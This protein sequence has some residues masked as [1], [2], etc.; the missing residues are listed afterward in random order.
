MSKPEQRFKEGS[1]EQF[2]KNGKLRCHGLAKSKIRQWREKYNDYD[3][4]S[5]DLWPEC[6]CENSA[7]EGQYV[8]RFHGGLTPRRI[9]PP[10]TVL[11]V[12][13]LDLAEKYQMLMDSPDY[14]SRKEDIN[15]LRVRIMS[16]MEDLQKQP[17]SD[18]V[19]DMVQSAVVCLRKGDSLNALTFL[20]D[21]IRLS[22]NKQKVW[23]EFHK[24]EKLLGD[25]TSTQM[26]TMKDMQTMATA[27]QVNALVSTLLNLINAGAQNYIADP[28]QR[29][30]FTRSIVS[31]MQKLMGLTPQAMIVDATTDNA[32]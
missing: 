27:E 28:M 13:P 32:D 5:D 15:L 18:E 2:L 10:R 29:S 26:K 12:L 21:A 9:N 19:W 20:E 22:D 25:M 31:E 7:E 30:Q 1:G 8:C 17:D 11:D 6:Q 3:T 4:P 24:T 16:L 14:M 23:D